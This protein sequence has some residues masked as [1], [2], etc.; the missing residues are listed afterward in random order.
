MTDSST[1]SRAAINAETIDFLLSAEGRAAA[2]ELTASLPASGN[3]GADL[4][5][6]TRLRKQ[7]TPPQA[8]A[9]MALAQLRDKAA[10]KFPE[11]DQLFFTAEALEQATARPI[12]ERRA[13]HLDA[14]SPPGPWLDL[15]C[16]IGGD[17]LALARLRPVIAYDLD[18]V[19]LRLA[20]AN[21]AALGLAD[22]VTFQ[23]ADWTEELAAGRLPQAAGA[24]VDPARRSADRRL[25]HLDQLQPPLH[26]WLRLRDEVPSLAVKVMP[27]ID[28]AEVPTGAGVEFISHEG[29]CKE[30]LLWFGPPAR[31]PRWASVHTPE[32]W[33][34]LIGDAAGET[35]PQGP[36]AAG[37]YLHEPDPA[38]IRAGAFRALCALLDAHLFDPEIAYVV[39]NAPHTHPAAQSFRVLEVHPFALHLL[40]ARVQAL[41]LG[42]LEL[43]KRGAPFAP[44]SLRS[45]IKPVA[46]G[47][48]GVV[49]FTRR[50]EARIMILADRLTTRG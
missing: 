34:T 37:M 32:R 4:R 17:T 11:A 5:L 36:L 20:Q 39:G 29:V 21:A 38:V 8:G 6:L 19:R 3:A 9:L 33:Y 44:E 24:F 49:I 43:K 28:L 47:R 48:P 13:A 30:A 18:P 35:P 22:Q 41:G 15:G 2:A 23:H 25:F 12:A 45:R 46:G 27:G 42:T 26:A 16:G 40:Q 7:Y 10:A 50:G 14:H 1:G 31:H